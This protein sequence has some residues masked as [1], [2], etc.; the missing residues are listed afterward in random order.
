MRTMK[1]WA[2]AASAAAVLALAGCGGG[3]SSSTAPTG[4]VVDDPPPPVA[5][6]NIPQTTGFLAALTDAVPAG[7]TT[8]EHPI[9]AA[10]GYMWA[11]GGVRFTCEADEAGG[12][13]VVHIT[14]TK[15]AYGN[16][17]GVSAT[18]TGGEVTAMFIDPLENM[19]EA[20]EA[21][22]AAMIG[23]PIGTAAIADDPQ[24]GD[25]D[26]TMAGGADNTAMLMGLKGP[27]TIGTAAMQANAGSHNIDGVTLTG[28]FDPNET[29]STLRAMELAAVAAVEAD[30]TASPP[31]VAMPAMPAIASN[32]VGMEQAGALGLYGWSHKVLHA[33]WG[34]TTNGLDAGIETTALIYSDVKPPAPVAFADLEATLVDAT[35]RGWF[36]LTDVDFDGDAATDEVGVVAIADVADA[37]AATQAANSSISPTGQTFSGLIAHPDNNDVVE[38][39]Y[40]GA[41]GKFRCVDT[42]CQISRD[43]VTGADGGA[44]AFNLSAGAWQFLPDEGATVTIP[45]QDWVAFGV[46]LTAPDNMADGHH[47]VGVFYDGMETYIPTTG[48]TEGT[49]TFSGKAAGYYVNGEAHGLFTADASLTAAF[50]DNMLSGSIQNFRDSQGRYIDTDNPGTPNDPNAGGENDWG[51]SLMAHAFTDATGTFGDAGTTGGTADG[52]VWSG[53]W[54]AQLYGSGRADPT[55]MPTGVAGNFNAITD[56]LST[57][58]YKG[59]VGAFGAS[60]PETQ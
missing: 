11:P 54:M 23:M 2:M 14:V 19:N 55:A 3:G 47:N 41:S 21:T 37:A 46:W 8:K 31:V 43:T 33:D 52:V 60:A 40:F 36:T 32:D 38:G 29:T 12:T 50:A 51:V 56:E 22:I 58:G 49:A 42:S 20:N 34:D 17:T 30:D 27:G 16:V 45:D 7:E 25:V 53:N 57:G 5:I 15:D 59:V 48:L 26:E 39:T 35:L 24:T 28:P 10:D 44:V 4:P 18:S 13:C 9:T 1:H 6:A